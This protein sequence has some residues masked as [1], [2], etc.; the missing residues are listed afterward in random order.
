MPDLIQRRRYIERQITGPT[1]EEAATGAFPLIVGGWFPDVPGT[2]SAAFGARGNRRNPGLQGWRQDAVPSL[3]SGGVPSQQALTALKN[4]FWEYD[5]QVQVTPD[6]EDR[7]IVSMRGDRDTDGIVSTAREWTQQGI[8]PSYTPLDAVSATDEHA[9]LIVFSVPGQAAAIAKDLRRY[10]FQTQILAGSASPG[11]GGWN[12]PWRYPPGRY[13]FAGRNRGYHANRYIGPKYQRDQGYVG[14]HFDSYGGQNYGVGSVAA[15]PTSA[16][17]MQRG[18]IDPTGTMVDLTWS[19]GGPGRGFTPYPPARVG[20][21]NFW[22]EDGYHGT[23]RDAPWGP[24]V[25]GLQD[26]QGESDQS[27]GLV[28]LSWADG[29]PGRYFTPRSPVRGSIG[30]FTAGEGYHGTFRDAPFGPRATGAGALVNLNW[31]PGGPGQGHNWNRYSR[32]SPGYFRRGQGFNTP[33]GDSYGPNYGV[34]SL[35]EPEDQLRVELAAKELMRKGG[36]S[37]GAPTIVGAEPQSGT[38]YSAVRC[39][40]GLHALAETIGKKLGL[41]VGAADGQGEHAGEHVV[42]FSPAIAA[43]LRWG[44]ETDGVRGNVLYAPPA[45]SGLVEMG[46]G[47]LVGAL[48]AGPVG[49]AVGALFG[50]VLSS[51]QESATKEAERQAKLA[52]RVAAASSALFNW[53]HDQQFDVHGRFKSEGV[54]GASASGYGV[55]LYDAHERSEAHAAARKI[56]KRHGVYYQIVPGA[57][58][59]MPDATETDYVVYFSGDPAGVLVTSAGM[60]W[61]DKLKAKF[62][63]KGKKSKKSKS[64][65]AEEAS[66]GQ[67]AVGYT[68]SSQSTATRRRQAAMLRRA[69]LRRQAAATRQAA[70]TAQQRVQRAAQQ[71]AQQRAQQQTQQR[72]QQQVQRARARAQAQARAQLQSQGQSSF[73]GYGTD[74]SYSSYGGGYG[75]GYSSQYGGDTGVYDVPDYDAYD[76]YG[77]DALGYSEPTVIPI[78]VPVETA[79]AVD[80]TTLAA[81]PGYMYTPDGSLVPIGLATTDMFDDA[82]TPQPVGYDALGNPILA[83][84]PRR[85]VVGTIPFT[86]RNVVSAPGVDFQYP[87]G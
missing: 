80:P 57:E 58:A 39:P 38:P 62:K 76:A 18:L 28:N 41:G 36:L 45:S 66:S 49:A 24:R 71:R 12:H 48:V 64:S 22:A 9:H 75:G 4:S 50:T 87:V 83:G 51:E 1:E 43:I 26:E 8:A 13:D 20:L 52:A 40:S 23:F 53:A 72:V 21:G 59:D 5:P 27:D 74:S 25:Q 86:P 69:A 65:D 32:T 35:E 56:A 30:R 29:G 79:P 70:Q 77:G 37:Q 10:G 63:A 34:G 85:T 84:V 78:P 73:E 61:W 46:V 17:T 55:S 16:G 7:I 67:I 54:S 47:A 14:W 6:G 44:E 15:L 33:F 3:V 68:T 11:V 31:V 2:R 19:G 82:Y 81:P 60:E 42:V